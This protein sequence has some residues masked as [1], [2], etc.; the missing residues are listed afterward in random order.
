MKKLLALLF[1][2]FLSSVSYGETYTCAYLFDGKARALSLER[3]G[4]N[5]IN[6][7]GANW[8]IVTEDENAI[9]LSITFT[10]SPSSAFMILVDKEKLNFVN[11]GIEFG[12]STDIIEGDCTVNR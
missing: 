1:S 11:V 8:T 9:V 2:F 10:Q 6:D 3:V 7:W 12:N 4:N 5:F